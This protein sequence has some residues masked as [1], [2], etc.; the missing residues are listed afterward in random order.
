MSVYG[1]IED[2]EVRIQSVQ[3]QLWSLKEE[4]SKITEIIARLESE[5]DLLQRLIDFEKTKK[6]Q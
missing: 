4:Y 5:E 6:N 2:H 3:R 1:R